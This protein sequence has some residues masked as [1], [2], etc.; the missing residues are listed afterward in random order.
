MTDAA[1]GVEGVMVIIVKGSIPVM[2]SHNIT[3]KEKTSPIV[4]EHAREFCE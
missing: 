2:S 1:F 3:P 4:T